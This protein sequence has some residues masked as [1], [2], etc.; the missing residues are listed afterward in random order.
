M[1]ESDLICLTPLGV[2]HSPFS[3]LNGMPIQAAAGSGVAGTV[4]LDPAYADGLKD[5]EGFSHLILIFHLHLT[6]EPSLQVVPFLDTVAHGVFATRSPKR[7]NRLGISVV[8]LMRVEGNVLHVQDLDIVDGTPLLDIKPYVPQF[9]DR[10]D[11]RIGWFENNVERMH[12]VR[13]GTRP[14]TEPGQGG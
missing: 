5:I 3:Q 10:S 12:T 14:G 4:E 2:I 13:A 8:R 1:S 7:P 6:E 9:D 11:A